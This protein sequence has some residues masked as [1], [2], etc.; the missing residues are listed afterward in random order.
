[1]REPFW[2]AEDSPAEPGS[3][4]QCPALFGSIVKNL[5]LQRLN[6]DGEA[7]T[8]FALLGLVLWSWSPGGPGV[9][10][11]ARGAPSLL[12]APGS[13]GPATLGSSMV[14]CSSPLDVQDH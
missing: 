10:W 3:T 1:M 11:G 14:T 5:F 8:R 2:H 4:A 7:W 9:S 12:G 13:T 6:Q